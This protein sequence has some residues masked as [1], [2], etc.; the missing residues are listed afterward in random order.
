MNL[1]KLKEIF[2]L[3][4]LNLDT[5]NEGEH[6]KWKA[7]KCFQDNWDIESVH[8][9]DMLS[10]SLSLTYNLMDS[11]Q[12]FPRGMIEHYANTRPDT[13]RQLFR[14]LYDEE[15]DIIERIEKFKQNI[16][17]LNKDISGDG[18]T[19]QDARAI[20]VYL[21]LKYPDRYFFYKFEMFKDFAEIIDYPYTPIRGR[22]ENITQYMTLC[23]LIRE[24]ILEDNALIEIHK[25]SLDSTDFFDTSL[26]ILTQNVIYAAVKYIQQTASILP[27]NNLNIQLI[28]QQYKPIKQELVLKGRFVNYIENERENKIKGDLGELL[29]LE[30]EKRQLE[31][32]GIYD[33]KPSHDSKNYGDGLGYDILSYT[34]DR[35]KKYIEVK[36]TNSSVDRPFYITAPELKKSI[37]ESRSFYLYRLFDFEEKKKSGKLLIIIGNLTK[38]CNNPTVYKAVIEEE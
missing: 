15:V 2:N 28:T 12:Y 6:Y 29:I 8:F 25:N 1:V 23:R 9:G 33:L 22:N 20:I 30:Y 36:T 27:N 5:I 14:D 3:Y 26:N 16:E 38:Y 4:K 21:C 24:E 34:K 37:D 31:S 19:Y 10:K 11:G 18:K 7:V 13:V 32:Y 17:Q 35:K